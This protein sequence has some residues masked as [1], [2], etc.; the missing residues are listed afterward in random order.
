MIDKLY[1]PEQKEF[2]D[3]LKKLI[4]DKLLVKIVFS[5]SSNPELKQ[6][7]GQIVEVKEGTKIKLTFRFTTRDEVKNFSIDELAN[8]I[9]E[10]CP[11]TFKNIYT[12][13]LMGEVNLMYSKKYKPSILRK[14][15]VINK[16]IT[17]SH[18]REKQKNIPLDT[19]FLKHLGVTDDKGNLIPKMAD[20]FRQINRYIEIVEDHLK[21]IKAKS[22]LKIVDMGS[23]KGYLTFA[24]FAYL[25][26]KN[27][28]A[29]VTG[30]E[31]R[32]EL[33]N[34]CNKIAHDCNYDGLQFVS[35]KIEDFKTDEIDVLIALHAC[36]TAT[37]D[38]I[39]AGINANC[40]LII[41][42]PCCHKQV[43]QSID[44]Q[45]IVN[46]IMRYGIFTERSCEMLTDTIRA[47]ILESK[48]YKTKVFEFVSNEHTR[49]NIMLSAVKTSM[50][51][52][53]ANE[54]QSL[55]LNYGLSTHYLEK[56]I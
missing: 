38:A 50:P 37:D 54:I 24:L 45:Q 19:F 12:E 23:G 33:A 44:K 46:P 4:E 1:A 31:L 29:Q 32:P 15:K 47:M 11:N 22:T 26:D 55:K 3:E 27:I 21:Q 16:E 41:C 7:H 14:N 39:A 40:E 25:K 9:S 49:K 35:K 6:I 36:D 43:R 17:S 48:G 28:S 51:K 8:F 18:N 10:H 42:A 20:K 13:S 5:K 34:L 2:V 53:N 30:V 56:L 52:D